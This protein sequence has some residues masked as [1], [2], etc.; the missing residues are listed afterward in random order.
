M[1]WLVH[2]PAGEVIPEEYILRA[3][4]L[5]NH[6]GGVVNV[7]TGEVFRSL[8]LDE[9]LN[10]LDE[11]EEMVF[12]IRNA[13]SGAIDEK[14][15]HPFNVNNYWLFHNGTINC[16]NFSKEES[17][18]EKFAN[19]LKSLNFNNLTEIDSFIMTMMNSGENRFIFIDDSV[20]IFNKE[21]GIQDGNI[22]YSNDYHLKPP[23]WKRPI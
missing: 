15:L 14:R 13:T 17:D 5:N 9:L 19:L 8:D 1:C 6:G 21:I 7:R 11:N 3:W 18:T 22:W 16:L 4:E 23:G 12:H 20:H 2:K 10:V